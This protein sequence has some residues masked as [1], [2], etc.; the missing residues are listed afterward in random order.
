[1]G[2]VEFD[3]RVTKESSRLKSKNEM[4]IPQPQIY[5]LYLLRG[6]D[7]AQLQKYAKG[8]H[9]RKGGETVYVDYNTIPA[10]SVKDIA[11][12]ELS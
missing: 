5:A 8:T 10:L 2:K 7:M 4:M 1:M 11:F 12:L 6:E 9:R 3:H